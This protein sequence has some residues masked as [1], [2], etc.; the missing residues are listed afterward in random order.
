MVQNSCSYCETI[1]QYDSGL[2]TIAVGVHLVGTR[3]GT[4]MGA[5][6][7]VG[8]M[9]VRVWGMV[10]ASVAGVCAQGVPLHLGR[11]TMRL[12]VV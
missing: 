8:E 3:D 5:G 2:C 9:R 7:L 11:V 12:C 4:V 6:D 1:S 10:G